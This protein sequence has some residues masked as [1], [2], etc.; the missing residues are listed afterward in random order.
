M[1]VVVVVVVVDAC[2]CLCLSALV[3][4][5]L[6][7]MP[8]LKGQRRNFS[9]WTVFCLHFGSKKVTNADNYFAQVIMKCPTTLGKGS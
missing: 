8:L 9:T 7:C 6:S 3:A 1:L 4:Y 5:L 2:L